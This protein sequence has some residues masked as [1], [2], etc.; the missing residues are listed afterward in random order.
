M[1]GR[2]VGDEV[3]R[4]RRGVGGDGLG[5]RGWGEGECDVCEREG[6]D[7]GGEGGTWGRSVR[8]RNQAIREGGGDKAKDMMRERKRH[9]ARGFS[10]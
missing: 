7:R 6:S 8:E 3:E 9:T 4:W 5:Q 10:G 1:R 2:R